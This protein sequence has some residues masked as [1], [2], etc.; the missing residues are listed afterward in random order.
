VDDDGR[1][2]EAGRAGGG[3]LCP[4]PPGDAGVQQRALADAARPVERGQAGG[5][6]VGDDQLDLGV[7]AGEERAVGVVVG[8]RPEAGERR[9]RRRVGVVAAQ[10]P[11]G[12]VSRQD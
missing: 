1:R 10:N 7:A 6:E 11:T 3:G 9:A 4:D 12:T 5:A 8:E 2:G